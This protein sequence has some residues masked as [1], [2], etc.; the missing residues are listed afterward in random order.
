MQNAGRIMLKRIQ[1][2]ENVCEIRSGAEFRIAEASFPAPFRSGLEYSSPARGT[3]NIVH[4]GMLIPQAH[5]ILP[6]PR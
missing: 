3:W 5:E 1:N 2:T 4:T 6:P